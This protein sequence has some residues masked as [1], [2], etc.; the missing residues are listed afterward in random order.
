M[1]V[2]NNGEFF[3]DRAGN[4]WRSS[5]STAPTLAYLKTKCRV[6]TVKFSVAFPACSYRFRSFLVDGTSRFTNRRSIRRRPLFI[7]RNF[8]RNPITGDRREIVVSNTDFVTNAFGFPVARRNIIVRGNGFSR[9]RT[10]S[11]RRIADGRYITVSSL[12]IENRVFVPT[13]SFA[14][15]PARF[16]RRRFVFSVPR[17]P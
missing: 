6:R 17:A 8:L 1:F 2:Y 16:S 15:F 13:V 12:A 9:I 3:R 10:R 5:R 4:S 14:S 7:A 11:G